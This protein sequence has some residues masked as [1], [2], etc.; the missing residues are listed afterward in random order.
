LR[1]REKKA[2][3]RRTNVATSSV[4]DLVRREQDLARRVADTARRILLIPDDL[5]AELRVALTEMEA[6]LE[7]VRRAQDEARNAAPGGE[8]P[9]EVCSGLQYQTRLEREPSPPNKQFVFDR[10]PHA[11]QSV[12]MPKQ[13]STIQPGGEPVTDD[14]RRSADSKRAKVTHHPPV[15]S[16]YVRNRRVS[17]AFSRT[18]RLLS[19]Q[20]LRPL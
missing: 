6:D 4:D 11:L 1:R 14:P 20:G 18:T 9:A 2:E 8:D 17:C 19:P 3:K 15:T 5:V 16:S 12:G 13:Y 7:R 10:A